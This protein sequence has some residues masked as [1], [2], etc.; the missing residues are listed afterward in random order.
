MVTRIQKKGTMMKLFPLL[1][2]LLVSQATLAHPG[3]TGFNAGIGLGGTEAKFSADEQLFAN[4]GVGNGTVFLPSERDVQGGSFMGSLALGYSHEFK[5]HF[6]LGVK[7]TA[8]FAN[9]QTSSIREANVPALPLS[10]ESRLKATLK[11][12]F[13]LLVKPG[14]VFKKHTQ[15]YA[16]LGPRWGNIE[17]RLATDFDFGAPSIGSSSNHVSHYEL[18]ISAGIGMEHLLTHHLSL[19]MEYT[20]TS[21]GSIHSP[22]NKIATIA[23]TVG[24]YISDTFDL[25]AS[26]NTLMLDLTYYF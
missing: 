11:N 21:Y 24:G 9:A 14:Y 8:N 5:H 7:A 19:G 2:L 10:I 20:Y 17:S 15:L 4:G 23:G 16:L 22:D 3:F 26:T 1:S 12:D 25:E 18:G 6:A 13:A